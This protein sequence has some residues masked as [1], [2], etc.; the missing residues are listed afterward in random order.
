MSWNPIGQPSPVTPFL[1]GRFLTGVAPYPQDQAAGPKLIQD[2]EHILDSPLPAESSWNWFLG[3][4]MFPSDEYR[5]GG[6]A[7]YVT[8]MGN[9]RVEAVKP[10]IGGFAPPMA[11]LRDAAYLQALGDDY[12]GEGS[13]GFAPSTVGRALELSS[14]IDAFY[15]GLFGARLRPAKLRPGPS[16]SVDIV[17]EDERFELFLKVP[18]APEIPSVYGENG[19]TRDLIERRIFS[20]ADQVAVAR[21]LHGQWT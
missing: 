6:P 12:D 3:K 5:T 4:A 9:V 16:G 11:Q 14:R 15:T 13:P 8:L 21:W 19:A 2:S 17:W 7:G 18:P 10:R 20:A 1:G